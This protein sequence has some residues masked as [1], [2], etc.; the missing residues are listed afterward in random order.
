VTHGPAGSALDFRR[1]GF[2]AFLF[3]LGR[4]GI[5]SNMR[6]EAL[7]RV[8]GSSQAYSSTGLTR[9]SQVGIAMI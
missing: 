9:S 2:D 8:I 1:A 5:T 6:A 3:F 7:L 4:S